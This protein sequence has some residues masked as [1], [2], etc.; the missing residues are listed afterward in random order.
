M[1][2]TFK[3]LSESNMDAITNKYSIQESLIKV[4]SK[5]KKKG[6]THRSVLGRNLNDILEIDQSIPLDAGSIAKSD[7]NTHIKE[8]I[9][10]KLVLK[11]NVK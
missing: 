4:Y 3:E 5:L 6:K 1:Y 11:M 2:R 9:I 10:G 8:E 7:G